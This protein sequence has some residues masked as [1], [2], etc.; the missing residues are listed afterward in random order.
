M[1]QSNRT[2]TDPAPLSG[3]GPFLLPT[4]TPAMTDPNDSTVPRIT[5]SREQFA[6]YEQARLADID[7]RCLPIAAHS[8]GLA[9]ETV[10]YINVHYRNFANTYRDV[11]EENE[12]M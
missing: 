1:K 2:T 7:M 11:I 10:Q 6:A 9:Q 12:W 5:V 4:I 8:S 3:A